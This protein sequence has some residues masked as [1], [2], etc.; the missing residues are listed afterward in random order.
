MFS[1]RPRRG[2]PM[3]IK[4]FGF[5]DIGK[6]RERNEDCFLVNEDLKLYAV[7]DGMG[8]HLGGDFASR[9]AVATLEEVVEALERDPKTLLKEEGVSLKAGE[10]Q[11]YLR[12]AIKLAS[13]R[14]F[15]KSNEQVELQG[16]GTTSV[17][18][19][20]RKN[21]AYIANVGDS[22]AYRIR[23]DKIA[24]ITKDHSLVSEQMRA[25]ILSEDDARAHR[26]KNIITR[27]VGFQ[28]DV[29]VDVDIRVVREG[30]LFFLCSDGLS[31]M[32]TD[33]EIRDII[34]TNESEVA[35]K[36]LVDIANE[37]GGDDNITV[38]LAQVVGLDEEDSLSPRDESTAEV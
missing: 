9:L 27:S 25:G 22:R 12:H 32:V 14:I 26:L 16:M 30:D 31:N 2:V 35:C 8:G 3:K 1:S 13:R 10:Y 17:V 24:Q 23:G 18:L 34:V 11:G 6:R 7:A 19:L 38:V 33:S 21:K 37:R 4:S 15:E 20:F 29:D 5:S 28:E 36:R